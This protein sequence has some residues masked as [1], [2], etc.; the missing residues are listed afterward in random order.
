MLDY[1]SYIRDEHL[2]FLE[3]ES[4]RNSQICDI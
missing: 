3:E 1:I 4:H 2:Q